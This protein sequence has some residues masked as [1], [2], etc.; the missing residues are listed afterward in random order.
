MATLLH[1]TTRRRAARILRV[2]PDPYCIYPEGS[3]GGFSTC[4]AT[5]DPGVGAPEAYA[6]AQYTRN[7]S[8]GGPAIVVVDVPDEII[9]LTLDSYF[10]LSQGLFQFEPGKGLEEL[11]ARW[12]KLKKR[13]LELLP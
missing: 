12:P 13:I 5:A 8:E 7:Q 2:G 6:W 9:A 4:L 10:P 1:G 11:R 3:D